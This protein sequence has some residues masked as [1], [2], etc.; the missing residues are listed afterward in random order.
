MFDW[1][2]FLQ[3]NNI[4]HVTT[5]HNARRYVIAIKCPFCADDPSHHMGISTRGRGYNCWRNHDHSGKSIS[6]LIVALL[7]CSYEQANNI[8]GA[9]EAYG[10]TEETFESEMLRS[11]GA[12]PEYKSKPVSNTKGLEF[13]QDFYPLADYG[14]CRKV[15]IPYLEDRGYT[16]DDVQ[17][18]AGRFDLQFA[19]TGPYSYRITIPVYHKGKLVNWTGRT[20][21]DDPMRY[22]SLSTDPEKAAA[23][24]LPVAPMNIKHC[25]FDYDAL[26][27]GG[28]TIAVCEGPFDA[29]RISFFGEEYGIIG[30]CVFS[31]SPLVEQIDL[32]STVCN[33]FSRRCLL[34]DT[35]AFD[36]KLSIPDSLGFEAIQ[37]PPGYGDPGELDMRGFRRTFDI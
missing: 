9:G 15:A 13:T 35:D 8:V 23:Q 25:L 34:F 28:D 5:G 33:R 10:I 30:T 6:R 24:G 36:A 31:K 29:M 18:L 1:L 7:G 11:L 22:K 17:E 12:K 14:L 32:L 4:D 21:T 26:M 2:T 19:S 20:V 16:Y 37:L 3:S 27:D